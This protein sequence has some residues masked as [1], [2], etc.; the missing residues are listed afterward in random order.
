MLDFAKSKSSSDQNPTDVFIKLNSNKL[1]DMNSSVIR[2]PLVMKK[3]EYMPIKD[4]SQFFQLTSG[5]ILPLPH[6][7][8][9]I[10]LQ[11]VSGILACNSWGT[12]NSTFIQSRCDELSWRISFPDS[13]QPDHND[14]LQWRDEHKLNSNG[15]G[16]WIEPS[17]FNHSCIPNCIVNQSGD[18]MF[19]RTNRDI[20]KN[21]ELFVKYTDIID[22][23]SKRVSTFNHWGEGENASFICNCPRCTLCRDPHSDYLE[24]EENTKKLCN[25]IMLLKTKDEGR[26]VTLSKTIIKKLKN[27]IQRYEK[28]NPEYGIHFTYLLDI[29]AGVYINNNEYNEAIEVLKLE[30][31]IRIASGINE[32]HIEQYKYLNIAGC[33][34][35][36]NQLNEAQQYIKLSR[37]L[38]GDYFK[39]PSNA[40]FILMCLS[41]AIVP[42]QY[43]DILRQLA[44]SV[45]FEYCY[46]QR[47]KNI[48]T[49][50]TMICFSC[51]IPTSSLV[52]SKCKKARYCSK[53]CQK[54]DWKMHKSE[55]C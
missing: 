45:D 35:P 22:S 37:E 5:S 19:I 47:R 26:L 50:T 16:L 3:L 15:S 36:L 13:N 11:R 48:T 55:C 33:Y 23:F 17:L 40:A 34:I 21:E 7:I 9:T 14:I 39:K 31:R 44:C 27:L 25:D 42:P 20:N 6:E 2:L 32:I 4:R 52:C 51:Y 24:L 41:Y 1:V 8:D 18:Y 49:M 10:P 46:Q 12:C 28:L 53:S 43:H 54:E 29:Q 30:R 38:C